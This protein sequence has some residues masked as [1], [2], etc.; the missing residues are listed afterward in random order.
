[1]AKKWNPQTES[2][3]DYTFSEE[4][5]ER[6][7]SHKQDMDR[8]LGAYPYDEYKRWISLTSSLNE[9]FVFKLVPD[10]KIISSGSCLI[11]ENFEGKSTEHLFQEPKTIQEAESRLPNMTHQKGTNINFSQIPSKHYPQGTH[12]TKITQSSI[13]LSDRLEQLILIQDSNEKNVLCELQFSFVC[14]LIGQ[15]YDAFEQWK[16]LVNLLCNCE[17]AV[18]K[19]PHVFTDLINILY[20]QL[21]EMPDDFFVDVI[22]KENFL[23]VNLHN[24]FENIRD[25]CL[26]DE[27]T[28][29]SLNEKNNK[30]KNYLQQ[31]FSFDFDSCPDEY[32]PVVVE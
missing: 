8:F 20:F 19:Y 1:M 29:K 14:F 16:N 28:L 15:V 26:L 11:G 7:K 25:A 2:I 31:R 5:L 4:E 24:L 12:P 9:S 17:R 27:S 21:K 22:S 18:L 30:F 6:F 10:L 13:D 3:D 23:T 32:Q